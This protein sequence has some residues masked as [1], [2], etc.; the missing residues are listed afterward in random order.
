MRPPPTS[1]G[2]ASSRCRSGPAR[3]RARNARRRQR[4]SERRSTTR[5]APPRAKLRG[6]RGEITTQASGLPAFAAARHR[7]TPRRCVEGARRRAA[8]GRPRER[9]GAAICSPGR[10]TSRGRG[11]RSFPATSREKIVVLDGVEQAQTERCSIRPERTADDGRR[12]ISHR[13]PR[14]EGANRGRDRVPAAGDVRLARGRDR[15]GVRHS[16]NHLGDSAAG[17]LDRE[18]DY[19]LE[20]HSEQVLGRSTRR[21]S[22]SRTGRTASART[23]AS[24]SPRSG[25]RRVPGRGSASTVSGGERGERVDDARSAVDVRVDPRPTG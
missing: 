20:E 5:L 23:A 16:D 22:G 19:T 12:K 7:G 11:S 4:R 6:E 13:S 15:G 18:I 8:R 9:G 25:S 17:T 1:S 14:G 21:S 10:S 3:S 24:R 2:C